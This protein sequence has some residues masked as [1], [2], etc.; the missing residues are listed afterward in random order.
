MALRCGRRGQPERARV[1]AAYMVQGCS[2]R[3]A[4]RLAGYSAG[5]ANRGTAA[6]RHSQVLQR[7]VLRELSQTPVAAAWFSERRIHRLLSAFPGLDFK[8][9]R[10]EYY[11]RQRNYVLVICRPT[12][13]STPTP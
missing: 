10:T 7:A 12:S 13:W 3:T 6:L 8:K 4:L 11:G 5:V 9:L 2:I 1:A